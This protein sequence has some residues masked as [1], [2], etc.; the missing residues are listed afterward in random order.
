M[1]S[2]SPELRDAALRNRTLHIITFYSFKGGVGRTM[3]LV[4]A[5][6][7]LARRGRKVLLVDFDLKAPGLST[8][9]LL[10]PEKPSPGIVE[11]VTEFRHTRRSPLVT[12]FL[13]AAK[14][15]GKK[16]GKL[17]VMPAGRRGDAEYRRM[18]NELNWRT[19]YRDED[20]FLLFEDTRLQW[21]AELHP[22]YVLIDARTGHTDIEGVCT[23]Q[24]ADAVVV[25]FYPN[26]Q[27]LAGLREVCRHIRD[28]KESGLKKKIK[29]HFVA[30]NVPDLDDEKGILRSHLREFDS[31][32]KMGT[33]PLVVHR[34]ETLRMLDQPIFVE[35]RP[36]SRLA[37]EYRSL[38]SA[39]QIENLADRG[40]ALLFLR[41]VKKKQ[42]RLLDFDKYD[43]GVWTGHVTPGVGRH[44]NQ[45]T[46]Q[47]WDDAKLL[48]C[49]GKY[50]LE[51]KEPWMALKRFDRVLELKPDSGAALLN[52]AFCQRLLRKDEAT[53]ED[54]LHYL[55]DHGNHMPDDR[56]RSKRKKYKNEA[57]ILELL[58]I[59][60]KDFLKVLDLPPV[61]V[62]TW[63]EDSHSGLW[64]LATIGL[65]LI[66]PR[67]WDHA[68]EC[69]EHRKIKKVI[70]SGNQLE[71]TWKPFHAFLLAVAHWGKA[72]QPERRLCEQALRAYEEI[73]PHNL[74]YS[75]EDPY[76]RFKFYGSLYQDLSLLYCGV[77]DRRNA[78]DALNKA[79]HEL[80]KAGEAGDLEYDLGVSSWTFQETTV[81]EYRNDCEQLRHMISGDPIRPAF[82]GPPG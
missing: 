8:Y 46:G 15:V 12:D 60:P 45:I 38:V 7:E 36:H 68:I 2:T 28:E 63:G 43:V 74:D 52:R 14:P 82:L 4:N 51:Y 39:L 79:L 54:L 81:S 66:Q 57:A 47:F 76:T 13:Y 27:N 75:D 49:V 21:E 80:G 33:F 62:I 29:L 71:P 65:R 17:W 10:R 55:R 72:G 78:E 18:L 56:I 73:M 37:R 23:R 20:G 42:S 48:F 30:S 26:E 41:E 50:L 44:L 64:L 22:D 58:S 16:G 11:Y 34:H 40:G 77:G 1:P 61:K 70:E 25:V 67:L 3:A 53:V 9:D 19:L 35:Q 31:E 6:V 5:G 32:L 59:S 24:L 69:L